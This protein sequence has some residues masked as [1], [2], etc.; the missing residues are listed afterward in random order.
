M[1]D[2]F[3]LCESLICESGAVGD[4]AV[5]CL[6][7]RNLIFESETREPRWDENLVGKV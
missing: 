5:N 2:I 1:G 3:I 4:I 6:I 7:G